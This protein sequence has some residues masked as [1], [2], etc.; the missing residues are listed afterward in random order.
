VLLDHERVAAMSRAAAGIGKADADSALAARVL[1]IADGARPGRAAA[2]GR[3]GQ[4]GR[5]AGSRASKHRGSHR[6]R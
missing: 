6:G 1:A 5:P 3:T 4:A 2:A